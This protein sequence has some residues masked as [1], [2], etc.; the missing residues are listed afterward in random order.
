MFKRGVGI[1]LSLCL[2]LFFAEVAVADVHDGDASESE[3]AA[4]SPVAANG[5]AE[6]APAAS[7]QASS[8]ASAVQTVQQG[9]RQQTHEHACHCLHAHNGWTADPAEQAPPAVVNETGCFVRVV[10][11][12]QAYVDVEYRPPIASA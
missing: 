5:T 4:L 8:V 10:A 11:P 7:E 12:A 6:P 1:L 2:S 3:V 9:A